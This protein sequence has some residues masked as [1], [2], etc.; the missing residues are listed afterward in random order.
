MFELD[1]H[2]KER[3][4]VAET[5][6]TQVHWQRRLPACFPLKM[7]HSIFCSRDTISDY[8]S[9]SGDKEE[10]SRFT[11]KRLFPHFYVPKNSV[12]SGAMSLKIG[13]KHIEDKRFAESDSKKQTR[14]M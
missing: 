3:K 1:K 14:N 8:F 10:R 2:T 7:G 13:A 11:R 6:S 5:P 4:S 9:I 12:N